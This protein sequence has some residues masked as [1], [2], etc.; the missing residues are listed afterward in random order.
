[1]A[2]DDVNGDSDDV[3]QEKSQ[4]KAAKYDSGAAD[5]EKVTDYAEEKEIS[6]SDGFSCALSIIGDRR[7]KEAAEKKAKEKELLKVSIKKED[8]D[9]I[10]KEMEISRILAEQTLREHRGDIVEALIT[11]E[12]QQLIIMTQIGIAMLFGLGIIGLIA[13]YCKLCTKPLQTSL[14]TR[15]RHVHEEGDLTTYCSTIE[16]QERPPS[17]NEAVR[18]ASSTNTY[19]DNAPP[20]Y[21]SPYN[22]TS[23]SEAPPSYPGTP[24]SQEKSLHQN[25]NEPPSSPIVQHM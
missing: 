3:Q 2:D 22:R 5:L 9:L 11:H 1:M 24:K 13:F 8:V 15:R 12:Q 7:D 19:S 21:G 14:R 6:S 16:G 25:S 17:Y 23:M 4:K 18:N 10:M 20:L